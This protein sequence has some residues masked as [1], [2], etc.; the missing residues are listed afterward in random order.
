MPSPPRGQPASQRGENIEDR[1]DPQGLTAS[2]P[3]ADH[4]S[5]HRPENRAPQSDRN[6]K[7]QS[8]GREAVDEGKRVRSAGD[9]GGVE[10]EE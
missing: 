2:Q 9:D 10:T 6:G 1:E 8:C 3:L 5:R 7:A 4:T